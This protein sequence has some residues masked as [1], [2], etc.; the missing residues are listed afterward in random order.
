MSVDGGKVRLRTPSPG[1]CEWR[2]YKAVRLHDSVCAA[3]FQDNQ[4]L[5]AW[6][7]DSA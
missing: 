5:I 4:A 2:D 6:C 3:S 7:S 1:A